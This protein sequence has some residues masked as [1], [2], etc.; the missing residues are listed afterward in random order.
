M[1]D[2]QIAF[3]LGLLGGGILAA[4]AFAIFFTIKCQR[5]GTRIERY[6]RVKDH[7]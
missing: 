3:L 6:L 2:I 4:I 7:G 5:C 1:S